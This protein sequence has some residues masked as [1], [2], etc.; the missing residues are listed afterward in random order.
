MGLNTSLAWRYSEQLDKE[1]GNTFWGDALQ[2]EIQQ[3]L[4]FETF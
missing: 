2:T 1:N 4:D 3:I